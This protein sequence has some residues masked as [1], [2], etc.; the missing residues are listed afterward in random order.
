MS[1]IKVCVK[2]HPLSQRD[3]KSKKE[4]QWRVTE[5]NSLQCMDPVHSCKFTFGKER[6]DW[7]ARA[8]IVSNV[9]KTLSS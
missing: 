2:I 4:E 9:N 3:T 5:S 7:R 1:N 6:I 8:F